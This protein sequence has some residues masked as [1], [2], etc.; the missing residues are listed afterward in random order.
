MSR[1][2]KKREEREER[3]K[4]EKREKRRKKRE[5]AYIPDG[6]SNA[7]VNTCGEQPQW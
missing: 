7:S 3:E 2:A 6:T 5:R 4:R 1:P